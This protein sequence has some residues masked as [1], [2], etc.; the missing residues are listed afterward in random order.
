MLAWISFVDLKA[1][2]FTAFFPK[3]APHSFRK[4]CRIARILEVDANGI[5]CLC[6][7]KI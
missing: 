6:A 1:E 5:R 7:A 4:K 2:R 3:F